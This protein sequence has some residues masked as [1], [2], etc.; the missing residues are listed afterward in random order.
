MSFSV[1]V[2]PTGHQPS[3]LLVSRSQPAIIYDESLYYRVWFNTRP[4]TASRD[5]YQSSDFGRLPIYA[6]A[7]SSTVIDAMVV[8]YYTV[9]F[10]FT[11][12][13]VIVLTYV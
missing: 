3:P 5:Y 8:L 11:H 12:S 2:N 1:N 13:V 7:P 4:K 9:S 10:L 6:S